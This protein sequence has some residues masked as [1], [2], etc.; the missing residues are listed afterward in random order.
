MACTFAMQHA[1]TESLLVTMEE[2]AAKQPALSD[3]LEAVERISELSVLLLH[4]CR[5]R[6][7]LS[8]TG[9][10]RVSGF[11]LGSLPLRRFG[12][13]PHEGRVPRDGQRFWRRSLGADVRLAGSR[14]LAWAP[15]RRHQGRFP[16]ADPGAARTL[17]K[18]QLWGNPLLL[19]VTRPPLSAPQMPP[20]HASHRLPLLHSPRL[21]SSACWSTVGSASCTE[22][23][24]L[25]WHAHAGLAAVRLERLHEGQEP[26][27]VVDLE[28]EVRHGA[29]AHGPLELSR[30]HVGV[31][32][33]ELVGVHAA[34]ALLGDHA[35][36][37]LKLPPLAALELHEARHEG[38]QAKR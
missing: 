12:V 20:V 24:R 37:H 3:A 18:L 2:W 38:L 32:V 29:L 30:V 15:Q 4:P 6:K 1:L 16:G 26:L 21:G 23:C 31:R 33:P 25:G 34:A 36:R 13:L 27:Q 28:L 7:S 10:I 19:R 22:S 11:T 9:G 5:D 17:E 14:A 35:P 8:Y